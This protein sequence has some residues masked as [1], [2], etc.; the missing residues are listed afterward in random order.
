M[1]MTARRW[2]RQSS[3]F[4]S[5]LSAALTHSRTH[6]HTRTRMRWIVETRDAN[7][8]IEISQNVGARARVW[9]NRTSLTAHAHAYTLA[10]GRETAVCIHRDARTHAHT[11]PSNTNTHMLTD[12]APA[13]VCWCLRVYMRANRTAIANRP[14]STFPIRG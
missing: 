3:V 6:T 7:A 12:C 10:R 1:T 5:V 4:A 14:S 13:Y 2:L 8:S 11:P 9:P